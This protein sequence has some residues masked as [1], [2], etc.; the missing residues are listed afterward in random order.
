MI[1]KVIEGQTNWLQGL[2][3]S[4]IPDPLPQGVTLRIRQHDLGLD[5]QGVVGTIPLKNGDTLQ[6]IPKIGYVNFFRLLFES[7]GYHP[8]LEGAFKDFVEYSMDE[9]ENLSDIVARRLFHITEEIMRRSPIC[10]R[11]KR[12]RQGAFAQGQIEPIATSLNLACRNA[13]PVVFTVKER[14]V[15][16]AENRLLTEAMIRAWSLLSDRNKEGLRETY[17]RWLRRFPRSSNLLA[18]IDTVG[19]RFARHGYSGVRDY[20]RHALLLAKI[21]LG[22][23]GV[24]LSEMTTVQGEAMLLNSADIF[25][26][27]LRNVIRKEYSKRGYIVT[28]GGIGRRTLY[29]NGTFDLVPDIVIE[30]ENQIVLIADAKYKV[31]VAS[32]HYQLITYLAA[33]Q[34][35]RGLLLAPAFGGTSLDIREYE[36]ATH[37]RAVVREIY[38]PMQDL[39]VTEMCLR[40]VVERFAS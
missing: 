11:V 24:G 14:T 31:P 18:D 25:E 38:L 28:K 37:P 9:E 22:L 23:F 8:R 3:I 10:A 6:I 27:Y 35:K 40:E 30:K 32:D 13:E 1:R 17:F 36:V 12:D 21:V 7:E 4:D 2:T 16:T 29:T 39:N 33:Y 15:D 26:K 5:I 20:Y 34:A 19:Q